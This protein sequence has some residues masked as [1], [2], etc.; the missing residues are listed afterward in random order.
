MRVIRFAIALTACFWL[1]VVIQQVAWIPHAA[2]PRFTQDPLIGYFARSY[3]VTSSLQ[4]VLFVAIA[5]ALAAYVYRSRRPWAAAALCILFVLA[6]WQYFLV[7]LP[8]FF[9]PP[10]GDGSLHGAFVSYARFHSM[11]LWLHLTKLFLVL[12]CFG[13]W[14]AVFSRISH[15]SQPEV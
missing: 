3:V 8:L 15:A 6:F 14:I 10:L 1:V 12:G 7:G 11:G 2:Q 5:A 9:R 4:I 13:L